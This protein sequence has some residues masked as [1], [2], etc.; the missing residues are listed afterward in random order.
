ML[1]LAAY[2][3]FLYRRQVAISWLS[4]ASVLVL[5]LAALLAKEQTIVLP[6]LLLLTDYWWNPGFSL[7]GVRHNWRLYGVIALGGVLGV[8]RFLPAMRSA[9]TAGFGLTD[10]SWYQ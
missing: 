3:V 2:A 8:Y 10:L 9:T 5:F 6:A 7:Q 1:M 4:T